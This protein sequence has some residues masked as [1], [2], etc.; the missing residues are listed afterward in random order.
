MS[1]PHEFLFFSL[2]CLLLASSQAQE[3]D[4]ADFAD[5]EV[6]NK[7]KKGRP[8][9]PLRFGK[10]AVYDWRSPFNKPYMQR[11]GSLDLYEER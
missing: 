2:L 4:G 11:L 10:R 7:F 3:Y 8:R 6:S 5:V 9:G 1:I